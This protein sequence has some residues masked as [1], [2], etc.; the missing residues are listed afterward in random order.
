MRLPELDASCNSVVS[1]AR[2]RV[3]S[4]MMGKHV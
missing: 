2:T 4:A 3:E 1:E